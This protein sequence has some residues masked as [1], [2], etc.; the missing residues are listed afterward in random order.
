MT[1]DDRRGASTAIF[2]VPSAKARDGNGWQSQD[3]RCWQR[4]E[5]CN[6]L[7]RTINNRRE[8]LWPQRVGPLAARNQSG[9]DSTVAADRVRARPGPAR[10]LPGLAGD[11]SGARFSLPHG[12]PIALRVRLRRDRYSPRR[13]YRDMADHSLLEWSSDV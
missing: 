12:R 9:R 10:R 3:F 7:G 2:E 11:F 5:R 6:L 1:F 8:L 13:V 4:W